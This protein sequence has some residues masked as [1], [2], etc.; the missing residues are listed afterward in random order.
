MTAYAEHRQ[1]LDHIVRGAAA[2]A[3]ALV[4]LHI[5][6]II[7]KIKNYLVGQALAAYP[8]AATD[9]TAGARSMTDLIV[10]NLRQQM[11]PI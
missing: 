7:A 6:R 11:P 1:I 3:E 9:S 4:R 10:D 2:E 8:A 5:D